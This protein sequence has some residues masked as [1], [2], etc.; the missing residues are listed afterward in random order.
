MNS[1]YKIQG[2]RY[3]GLGMMTS[4]GAE[5]EERAMNKHFSV[6]SC[7]LYLKL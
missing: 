1:R 2:K 7:I 6:F 5:P 4:M 3:K